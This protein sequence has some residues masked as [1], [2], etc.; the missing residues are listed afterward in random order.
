[1]EVILVIMLLVGLASS[2]LAMSNASW[3]SEEEAQY[4]DARR[5]RAEPS[6]RAG[7]KSAA[8]KGADSDI[9]SSKGP[10]PAL[11]DRLTASLRAKANFLPESDVDSPSAI[12]ITLVG[13]IMQ[14]PQFYC[15]EFQ[16]LHVA[17]IMMRENHL[18]SVPVVDFGRRII[19]TITIRD[20]AAFEQKR[21]EIDL[22]HA[23]SK[24]LP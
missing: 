17:R 10:K 5:H 3:P 22:R 2:L 12:E 21:A 20:I 18:R 1:M 13:R 19:G 16:P 24:Q 4:S 9:S 6:M 15:F 8:S 14:L 7:Q 11:A 23:R